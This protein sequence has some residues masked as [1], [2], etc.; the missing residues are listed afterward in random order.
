MVKYK[1]K[2]YRQEAL[3]L[4]REELKNRNCEVPLEPVN[5]KS[6]EENQIRKSI[7]EYIIPGI[8][9]PFANPLII[10]PSYLLL[11]K[12]GF[13]IEAGN[14]ESGFYTDGRGLLI[15]TAISLSLYVLLFLFS[16]LSMKDLFITDKE[17]KFIEFIKEFIN[18]QKYYL[19]L[20]LINALIIFLP[21]ILSGLGFD[22]W[23]F[24]MWIVVPV[25]IIYTIYALIASFL[26]F[27]K[28][29]SKS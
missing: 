29:L 3:I 1:Y 11:G 10:I 6:E 14:K 8:L 13:S 5:A 28:I 16:W 23:F 15:Y 21:D 18:S 19:P 17:R 22:F 4:A 25:V 7:F 26:Y 24:G 9:S 20:S 27:F 12:M 2:N